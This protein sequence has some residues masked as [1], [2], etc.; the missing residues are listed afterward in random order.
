MCWHRAK[1]HPATLTSIDWDGPHLVAYCPWLVQVQKQVGPDIS[2]VA[3][4]LLI[5]KNTGTYGD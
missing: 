5:K 1:G 2:A 3:E 4:S